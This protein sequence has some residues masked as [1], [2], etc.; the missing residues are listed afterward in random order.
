MKI[1]RCF[2][3]LT[4][5]FLLSA[6]G[7]LNSQ[8][9]KA[10]EGLKSYEIVKGNIQELN[11]V[12]NILIVGP[13]LGVDE[14]HH[15]C[16]PGKDGNFPSDSDIIFISKHNDAQRFAAGFEKAGLFNTE[17][18]L[19]IYY[20]RIEETIKRLKTMSR[21]EIAK[22]LKLK[23]APEMILFG[24]VKKFA[25]KIAPLR[26]VIVDVQYELE[27]YNPDSRQSL[28]IDVAVLD[29]FGEDLQTIIQET[30][31]RMD[32]GK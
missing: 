24:T 12:K 1:M 8:L 2:L 22:E 3:L 21:I 5:C 27:F 15:M 20:D 30:K 14:E 26:A 23:H 6:C 28:V 16:L 4:S 9:M 18:Y 17:L 11:G 32:A 7:P 29:A 31:K 13:F 25:H 10:S 19:E